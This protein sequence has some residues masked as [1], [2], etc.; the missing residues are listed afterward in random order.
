[1]VK[2]SSSDPEGAHADDP[3]IRAALHWCR[4]AGLGELVLAVPFTLRADAVT[5]L[6][7][8]PGV[9]HLVLSIDTAR[10]ATDERCAT[11]L[12][13]EY[14]WRLPAQIPSTL[15]LIAPRTR[16]TAPM[17]RAAMLAGV[18]R[19]IY[20]SVDD[21][22]QE[23][24][25]SLAASKLVGKLGA[26]LQLIGE[27]S[28]GL[29]PAVTDVLYARGMTRAL[30]ASATLGVGSTLPGRLLIACP[31]LVAGG[32]ERQILNTAL[33]LRDRGMTDVSLLVANLSRRP[34]NDF[35]LRPLL[36]AGIQVNEPQGPT[37]QLEE[38]IHFRDDPNLAR[39]I[40][41]TRNLLSGLPAQLRQDILDH[42]LAL[43]ELRPSVVHCWLDYSNVRAG[44]AALLA[45]VPRVVLSGRN[46]GPKHFPYIF[47]ATMRAAYRT[48][49]AH[50]Q[51]ILVNNSHAGAA[52]YADWLGLP[53]ER[54]RVIYNGID[55]DAVRRPEHAS[56]R[57]FRAGLGIDDTNR[58]VGGMFRFS[59]EKRP[60][61]WLETA[62]RLVKTDP[63]ARCLLFGEGPLEPEMQHLLSSADVGSRVRI[64][65]PT[66]E[67]TLALAA[68]DVL[69]LTSRW[70]GTPNVAI[71]AQTLGTPVVVTGGGGAR[72]SFAPG[73]TGLFV[74][75]ARAETLASAVEQLLEDRDL[76][77][78]IGTLGRRFVQERFG[79]DRM[80]DET[81]ALYETH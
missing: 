57:A 66:R 61:L 39:R 38:W 28:V 32:A 45:G 60:L 36:D 30:R 33:G 19:M 74:E 17:I 26:G 81:L 76:R 41:Q 70:E 77:E 37:D 1:M 2:D 23:S 16:I 65:A 69:L 9:S 35:F 79:I 73:V 55:L 22:A 25:W 54:F 56:I 62:I 68:L 40:H 63:A 4:D 58:V 13:A 43:R 15:V 42:Y 27:R 7:G 59:P 64:L 34:G 12:P 51:V 3:R 31:T 10:D 29:V 52:D 44:L 75:T 50:P 21:W 20:W 14:S 24:I 48:L 67:S 11:F 18:R 71:E 46:V 72:E 80:I 47:D 5:E 53:I 78:G 8:E 49:A 6:L